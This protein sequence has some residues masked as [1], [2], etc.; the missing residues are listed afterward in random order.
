MIEGRTKLAGQI[1][2]TF[3]H[4]SYVSVPCSEW[5]RLILNWIPGPGPLASCGVWPMGGTIRPVGGVRYWSFCFPIWAASLPVAMSPCPPQRSLRVLSQG[6]P[7]ALVS[8][9]FL[10]IPRCF[11]SAL[12]FLI[13]APT[14]THTSDSLVMCHPFQ[15]PPPPASH[16]SNHR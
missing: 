14:P 8:R 4:P 6:G 13:C 9:C 11:L 2:S 10:F 1:C 16:L 5:S 7:A 3:P 15:M 12:C